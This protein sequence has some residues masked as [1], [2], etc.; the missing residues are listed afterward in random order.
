MLRLD[1]QLFPL[2]LYAIS[3]IILLVVYHSPPSNFSSVSFASFCSAASTNLMQRSSKVE[4]RER[5]YHKDRPHCT[6]RSLCSDFEAAKTTSLV[7]L[8]ITVI[9]SI[10]NTY[11]DPWT[12]LS[13]KIGNVF[14]GALSLLFSILCFY[15]KESLHPC[16][17]FVVLCLQ[18]QLLTALR[19]CLTITFDI[20][21]P[22]G[23]VKF[24]KKSNQFF[25]SLPFSCGKKKYERLG[26]S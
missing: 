9:H 1:T 2:R 17:F 25:R 3:S 22:T 20:L 11:T 4:R 6:V 16:A 14:G 21:S 12:F 10:H 18:P 19:P 24:G 5:E 7:S 13:D 8:F 26:R 23:M 15:Q